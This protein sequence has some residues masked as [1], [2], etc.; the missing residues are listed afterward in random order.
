MAAIDQY[1]HKLLGFINCPSTYDFVYASNTRDIAVYELFQDIPADEKCFDGKTGDILVG[2]GS[3]EAP[4]LRIKMPQ[5]MVFFTSENSEKDPHE[6]IRCF[7]T[8]ANAF[9]LCEGF[10]KVGWKVNTSIE[11][12]LAENVCKALI[13][14]VDSYKKFARGKELKTRLKWRLP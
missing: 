1:Q 4:A 8:P 10:I 11:I 9:V 6:F 14:N 12:W 13:N 3:G 5:S 7:W 2:G